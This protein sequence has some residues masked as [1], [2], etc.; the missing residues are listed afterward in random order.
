MHKGKRLDK[1][2]AA[3]LQPLNITS[4]VWRPQGDMFLTSVL[5]ALQR[6]HS[7]SGHI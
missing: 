1:K 6:F 2:E 3:L 5:V 4:F 7:L